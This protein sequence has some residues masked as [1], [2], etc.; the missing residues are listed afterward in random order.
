MWLGGAAYVDIG[1]TLF[2]TAALFAWYRWLTTE[3]TSW[4]PLAA[5]FIGFACASKYLGLFF[6]GVL[7]VATSVVSLRRR[8]IQ[9]ILAFA[10]VVFGIAGPW[11][12]R[13]VYFTGNPVFPYFTNVFGASAWSQHLTPGPSGDRSPAHS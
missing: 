10:A 1:L 13:I 8:N 7:A 2:V 5:A 11:Y 4:L 6:L 12:A 3:R 9:A